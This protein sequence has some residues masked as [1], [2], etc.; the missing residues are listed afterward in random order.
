MLGMQ[1]F[2]KS[3]GLSYE[4][5]TEE[6]FNEKWDSW[7]RAFYKDKYTLYTTGQ[8]NAFNHWWHENP[9]HHEKYNTFIKDY[10]KLLADDDYQRKVRQ[11]QY[12]AAREKNRR[13]Y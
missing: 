2:Y 11:E 6:A 10:A 12:Q 1:S 13:R 8:T 3:N 7:D 4:S 9:E 5:M